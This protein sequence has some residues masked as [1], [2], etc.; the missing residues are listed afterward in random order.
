MDVMD[1]QKEDYSKE[2]IYIFTK[3][4][5][6]LRENYEYDDA[7]KLYG[8][9]VEMCEKDRAD[10]DT[11]YSVYV[12][13]GELCRQLVHYMKAIIIYEKAIECSSSVSK[14]EKSQCEDFA[15]CHNKKQNY[16]KEKGYNLKATNVLEEL[17]NKRMQAIKMNPEIKDDVK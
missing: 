10:R 11:M 14:Q 15:L 8:I 5:K 12:G 7:L 9:M 4:A 2:K 3:F 13:M 16:L 1:S 6:F 17:V